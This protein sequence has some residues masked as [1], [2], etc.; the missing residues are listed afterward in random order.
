MSVQ[1]I[2]RVFASYCRFIDD[3][4]LDD[5][6]QLFAA[7]GSLVLEAFGI[8]ATGPGAIRAKFSEITDPRI[9]GTHASFNHLIDVDGAQASATADF[10][11]IDITSGTPTIIVV[12]RYFGKFAQVGQD[13]KIKEWKIDVRA[14]T[15]TPSK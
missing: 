10:M 13:W 14:N 1:A 3:G 7:D 12:G 8:R 5:V 4:R 11:M 9:K 6:S 15:F 2:Q